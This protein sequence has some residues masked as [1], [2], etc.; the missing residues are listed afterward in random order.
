MTSSYSEK[1][2]QHVYESYSSPG[3]SI[4]GALA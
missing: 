3:L 4:Y 2:P 1:R